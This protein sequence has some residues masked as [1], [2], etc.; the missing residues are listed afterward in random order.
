MVKRYA[1]NAGIDEEVHSRASR[2][3]SKCSLDGQTPDYPQASQAAF[4]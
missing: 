1:E 2:H 4:E 3:R